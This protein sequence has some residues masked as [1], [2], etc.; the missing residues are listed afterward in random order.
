MIIFI[1]LSGRVFVW[2]WE[3]NPLQDAASFNFQLFI[4]A[5][6]IK[7]YK[8]GWQQWIKQIDLFASWCL[9]QVKKRIEAQN[10]F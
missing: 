8:T 1:I 6:P 3:I 10:Y 9:S 7:S 4:C 5:V 2:D